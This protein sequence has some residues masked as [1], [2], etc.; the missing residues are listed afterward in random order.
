VCSG[1]LNNLHDVREDDD[2]DDD[3]DEDIK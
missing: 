3:D 2:D 1:T